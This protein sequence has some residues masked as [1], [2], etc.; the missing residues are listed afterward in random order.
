MFL[1]RF[2]CKGDKIIEVSHCEQ[3]VSNHRVLLLNLI[4][5]VILMINL[6]TV[7]YSLN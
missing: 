7:T 5:A 1:Q 6:I 2:A 3:H 4:G